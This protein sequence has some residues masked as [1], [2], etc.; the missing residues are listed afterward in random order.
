LIFS[1]VPQVLIFAIFQKQIM[2]GVNIGGVKG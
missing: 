1:V 2:G